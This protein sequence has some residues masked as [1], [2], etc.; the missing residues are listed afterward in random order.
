MLL[1]LLGGRGKARFQKLQRSV[2]FSI[3][4]Q[5][6]LPAINLAMI[7]SKM[8]A[9]PFNNGENNPPNYVIQALDPITQRM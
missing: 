7:E 5:P 4:L 3:R 8:A 6:L 2:S 9:P 1:I